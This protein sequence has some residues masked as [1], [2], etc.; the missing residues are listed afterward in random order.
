MH[1]RMK[2]K[3]VGYL[4][5]LVQTLRRYPKTDQSVP[6]RY[7]RAVAYHR[8]RQSEKAIGIMDGLLAEAPDDA[9]FHE[10]KG[11]I[12]VESRR[13]EEAVPSYTRAVQL[14]QDNALLRIGLGQAQLSVGDDRYVEA[15]LGHLKAATRLEP[16]SPSAWRWLA[17]AYGRDEQLAMAALATSERYVLLGRYPEA[18][19]LA[20]RALKGLPKSSP[21]YLRASDL[22]REAQHG[23]RR[24]RKKQNR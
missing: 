1:D 11:Q 18:K 20:V 13:I 17:M 5:S 3:L 16:R 9:Y 15:A 2:A 7:A 4:T 19:M 22:E 12:L 6:A 21:A 23:I 10:L 14:N 8:A 24:M